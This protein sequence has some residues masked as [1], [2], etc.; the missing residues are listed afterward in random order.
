MVSFRLHVL[1]PSVFQA[2]THA[3]DSRSPTQLNRIALRGSEDFPAEEN[4]VV[5]EGGVAQVRSR[6][7]RALPEDQAAIIERQAILRAHEAPTQAD[8]RLKKD[9]LSV[10][11]TGFPRSGSSTTLSMVK[12]VAD[13]ADGQAPGEVF[14]LFEPCHDGDAVAASLAEEGCSGLLSHIARCDFGGVEQLWGWNQPHSTNNHTQIFSKA[15]ATEYCL[16]AHVIAFKTVDY[17]HDIGQFLW[18]LDAEPTLRVVATVRDPRGIYASW[19]TTEPFPDLLRN[20]ESCGTCPG[21]AFYNMTQLCDAFAANLQVNDERVHTVVFE[22]LLRRPV[23]I[24]R[25]VYNFLGASFSAN[26]REW[27]KRTFDAQDCPEEPSWHE[28]FADC[29]TNSAGATDSWREALTDEELAI[30]SS[31]ASCRL[32]AEA[33]GYPTE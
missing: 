20:P 7:V 32:V 21:G 15:L 2:A 31:H 28:G 17:G 25:R 16:Q 26:Q 5:S 8:G 19:K 9:R 4:V 18:L 27:I 3:V 11:V 6:F 22:E 30:F 10:W 29:H 33:Y 14:S 23:E 13:I 12:A 1:L 24:T